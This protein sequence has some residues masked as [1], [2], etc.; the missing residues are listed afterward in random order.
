MILKEKPRIIR[1]RHSE[2]E[3][4]GCDAWASSGD[5]SDEDADFKDHALSAHG[6]YVNAEFHQHAVSANDSDMH[7]ESEPPPPRGVSGGSEHD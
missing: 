2:D 3:A 1:K 6:L 4:A 5:D 7:T